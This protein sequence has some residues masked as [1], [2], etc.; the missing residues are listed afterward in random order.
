[1]CI[2]AVGLLSVIIGFVS[3]ARQVDLMVRDPTVGFWVGLILSLD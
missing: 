2:L 1:M 3:G